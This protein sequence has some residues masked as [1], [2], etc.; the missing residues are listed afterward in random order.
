[1]AD[2]TLPQS[3]IH[4]SLTLNL[5]TLCALLNDPPRQLPVNLSE[6]LDAE[7]EISPAPTLKT[8]LMAPPRKSLYA[9]FKM[10]PVDP[11]ASRQHRNL[12]DRQYATQSNPSQQPAPGRRCHSNTPTSPAP[13]TND[14]PDNDQP[15][16]ASRKQQTTNG[17]PSI[18]L[19]STEPPNS[20]HT[21][22]HPHTH[23][24]IYVTVP[25]LVGWHRYTR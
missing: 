1:M 16:V 3:A 15:L 8:L 5:T 9:D 22:T 20:T 10:P 7:L 14:S 18:L 23:I 21:Y 6:A 4:L 11:T 2:E 12:P 24:Y 13:N 25:H 19:G 17:C